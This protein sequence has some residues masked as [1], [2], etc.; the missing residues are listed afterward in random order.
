MSDTGS[1]FDYTEEKQ[2][3]VLKESKVSDWTLNYSNVIPKIDNFDVE[4]KLEKNMKC[5]SKHKNEN[6]L[7]QNFSNIDANNLSNQNNNVT[8]DIRSVTPE[9]VNEI[10]LESQTSVTPENSINILQNIVKDSIKKSHKKIRKLL[11]LGF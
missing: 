2:N 5:L 11:N 3:N 10:V 8:N 9:S 6:E 7:F 4:V 1:L